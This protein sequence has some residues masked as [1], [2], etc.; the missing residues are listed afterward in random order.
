MKIASK[1]LSESWLNCLRS[2]PDWLIVAEARGEEMLEVL[3]SSLTG[4][5]IITTIHAL[6]I[7]NMPNRM[8]RMIM[9]N[10]QK[11]RFDDVYRDISHNLRFY[12][13]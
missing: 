6:D 12:I 13:Y 2:N 4:H 5:P 1:F 3:N 9:M 7:Y 10:P 8:A 11:L